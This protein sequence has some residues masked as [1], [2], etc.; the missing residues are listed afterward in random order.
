MIHGNDSLLYRC[1]KARY[2]PRS[3]F[4][5]A[6]ESPECSYV[7]RSLVAALPILQAGYYWRVDNGSSISVIGD[8]WIP[9]HPTN[10]VLHPN[11][12]LLDEMAVLDLINPEIHV[13]RSELITSIFHRED[14]TTICRIQLSRNVADSIIWSYNKNGSFSIK[15]A[16]KVA[17]K[18]QGEDRAESSG[19]STGKKAWNALWNLRIPN[20][21]KVFGWRALLQELIVKEKNNY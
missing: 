1:F 8:R 4:L 10:K 5:D 20:K 2:F 13:W 12:E 17:R 3:S 18:I 6:K 16:Y 11:H 14:A 21:I 15:S 9:N 7:W 19:G